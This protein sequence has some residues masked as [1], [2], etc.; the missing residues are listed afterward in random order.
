MKKSR[1]CGTPIIY[2][3]AFLFF[4]VFLAIVMSE[5]RE[6]FL[7]LVNISIV[8]IAENNNCCRVFKHPREDGVVAVPPS[9]MVDQFLTIGISVHAPSQAVIFSAGLFK[10]IT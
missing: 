7:G 2:F 4:S 9:I 6:N 5:E 10:T 8:F 3:E 1:S